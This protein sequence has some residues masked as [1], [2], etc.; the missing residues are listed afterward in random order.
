MKNFARLMGLAELTVA[1]FLL[2]PDTLVTHQWTPSEIDYHFIILASILIG[3]GLTISIRGR[4]LS[5]KE[6]S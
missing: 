1:F 2:W 6:P 5:Q 3:H 4:F